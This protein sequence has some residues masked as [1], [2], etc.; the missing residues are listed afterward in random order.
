[1]NVETFTWYRNISQYSIPE[2]HS[3]QHRVALDVLQRSA[4]YNKTKRMCCH[5]LKKSIKRKCHVKMEPRNGN[6]VRVAMDWFIFW[7]YGTIGTSITVTRNT[8]SH[9]KSRRMFQLRH[10]KW[11]DFRRNCH[12]NNDENSYPSRAPQSILPRDF[13]S[14]HSAL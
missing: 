7:V 10:N 8:T 9:L 1:M 6:N 12:Y 11:L 3:H 14:S 2:A 5:L 4:S 13:F